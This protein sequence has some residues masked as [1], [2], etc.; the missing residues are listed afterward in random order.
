[1]KQPVKMIALSALYLIVLTAFS[2]IAYSS[3]NSIEEYLVGFDYQARKDMKIDS[4]ELVEQYKEG[5]VQ[6]V[7]IRFK[8]EFEA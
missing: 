4:K 6:L 8:E 1:M 2:S 7:D 3:Q 5:K